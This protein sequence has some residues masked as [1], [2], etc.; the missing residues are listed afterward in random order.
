MEENDPE[1]GPTKDLSRVHGLEAPNPVRHPFEAHRQLSSSL[2]LR[3]QRGICGYLYLVLLV[4]VK[5][6]ILERMMDLV[7]ILDAV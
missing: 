5:I 1:H 7:F 3:L 4:I 2:R 6:L